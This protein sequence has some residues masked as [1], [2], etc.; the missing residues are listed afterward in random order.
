MPMLL[1]LFCGAGGA[2]AGYVLAGFDVV[3]VDNMA[4]PRYPYPFIHADA[5]AVL[6]RKG[7]LRRFDVIHASPPCQRYTALQRAIGNARSHPDLV[8]HVR[9]LLG[10]RP[11]VMEN[12]PGAPLI[13]AELMCGPGVRLPI[14]RH[15]LF[16]SNMDIRGT[17]CRHIAGGTTKGYYI[18]FR[19]GERTAPGR[20]MPLRSDQ[21]EYRDAI[22]CGW[23]TL[24]EMRQCV[25]PAYTRHLGRQLLGLL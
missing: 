1:D 13:G 8:G 6:A 11:Y 18:A 25:P 24:A 15:R 2:S 9:T 17:G 12:V 23:M 19:T 22:G 7:F 20:V 14:V 10:R 16:E 5:L 4:Q 21:G 3:G